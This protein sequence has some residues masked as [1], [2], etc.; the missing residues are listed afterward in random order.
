MDDQ[1]LIIG[2]VFEIGLFTA[3]YL[4]QVWDRSCLCLMVNQ[5]YFF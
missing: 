4:E 5:S 2:K 1:R 3:I